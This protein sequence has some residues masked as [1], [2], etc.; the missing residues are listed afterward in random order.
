MRNNGTN[1]HISAKYYANSFGIVSL[2]AYNGYL[3]KK[4]ILDEIDPLTQ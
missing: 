3:G 1:I 4:Y 2:K